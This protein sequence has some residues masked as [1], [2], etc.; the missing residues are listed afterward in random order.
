MVPDRPTDIATYRA[1]PLFSEGQ[2][3]I[4]FGYQGCPLISIITLL[5]VSGGFKPFNFEFTNDTFEMAQIMKSFLFELN[6]K[7]LSKLSPN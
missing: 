1:V 2:L 4:H 6:L 7:L 3:N 5:V